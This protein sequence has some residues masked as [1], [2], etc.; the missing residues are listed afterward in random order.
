M[1]HEEIAVSAYVKVLALLAAVP[2]SDDRV[3]TG[4]AFGIRMTDLSE[5]RGDGIP[6]VE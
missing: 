6:N 5:S 4:V 3:T 2:G 1:K